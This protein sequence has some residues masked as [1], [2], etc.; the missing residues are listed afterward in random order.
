MHVFAAHLGLCRVGKLCKTHAHIMGNTGAAALSAVILTT[1]LLFIYLFFIIKI[2][3]EVQHIWEQ[4]NFKLSP[5]KPSTDG[6]EYKLPHLLAAARSPKV[7]KIVRIF[8]LVAAPQKYTLMSLFHIH[9]SFF[10]EWPI[11]TN[12]DTNDAV[13]SQEVR[14]RGRTFN[15]TSSKCQ[16][17]IFSH[18]LP[19]SR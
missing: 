13:W 12:G 6:Y 8:W 19:L 17:P 14:F 7:H 1:S 3:H 9:C 2:V 10:I 11:C 5:T 18:E 16:N 4:T 15:Q